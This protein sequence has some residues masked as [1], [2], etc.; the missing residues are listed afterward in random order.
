[1][2]YTFIYHNASLIQLNIKHSFVLRFID[3][4]WIFKGEASEAVVV[5]RP[6]AHPPQEGEERLP[7]LHG[8]GHRQREALHA[9][10]LLLQEVQPAAPPLQYI[11]TRKSYLV[12]EIT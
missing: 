9:E 3:T 2:L 8:H 4:L 7:L 5:G 10:P 11:E 12:T 6:E 1:M